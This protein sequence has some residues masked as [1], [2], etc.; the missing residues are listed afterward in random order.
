MGIWGFA[1][2]HTTLKFIGNTPSPAVLMRKTKIGLA[3]YFLSNPA[4]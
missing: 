4:K 2:T 1:E 3:T